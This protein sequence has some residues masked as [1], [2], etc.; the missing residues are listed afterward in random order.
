MP[1]NRFHWRDIY[2]IEAWKKI[3]EITDN[4]A[5]PDLYKLTKLIENYHQTQ[6]DKLD[7]FVTRRAHLQVYRGS[8]PW[9]GRGRSQRARNPNGR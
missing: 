5:N 2:S 8:I 1:D 6:K 7:A 4:A 3:L 9:P